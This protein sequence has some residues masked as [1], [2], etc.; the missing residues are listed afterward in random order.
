[1]RAHL[2]GQAARALNK[3]FGVSLLKADQAVGRVRLRVRP[4][5][6]ELLRRGSTTLSLDPGAAS[7]LQSLGVSASPIAPATA[8]PGGLSFPVTG[9]KVNAKTY[10]G[11]IFHL[12]ESRS[13]RARPASS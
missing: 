8:G 12:E 2:N 7:A 4:E 6:V 3:A 1:M 9:G 10:A 5:Q 11:S 13:R